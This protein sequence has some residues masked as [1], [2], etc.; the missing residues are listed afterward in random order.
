M[1]NFELNSK[2]IYTKIKFFFWKFFMFLRSLILILTLLCFLH[3]QTPPPPPEVLEKELQSAKDEFERAQKLFNPWFSGP[4]LTGSGNTFP[5]GK[6]GVQPY[7]NIIDNYALFSKSGSSRNI[8]DI[9]IINP[10]LSMLTG[11]TSYLEISTDFGWSFQQQDGKQGNGFN[12][13]GLR[14]G[15]GLS[16]ETETLP[17]VKINI[18]E[19]FPTGRYQNLNPNKN[20]MDGTG[21]G[22]YRTLVGIAA[23][24]VI[25]Y[26]TEHPISLRGSFTFGIPTSVKVTGFNNYGGGYGTNGTVKPGKSIAAAFAFEYSINQ[27][28]VFSNDFVYNYRN[29][30]TFSGNPG[31]NKD[32]SSAA[33]G[34][35]FSDQ[36]SLAPAI[37]Y[38]PKPDLNFIAGGWFAV[39]GRN[40]LRFA[41]F[42]ASVY[43]SF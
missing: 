8:D 32:G 12:D 6:V 20:G 3:A 25:L 27:N 10:Y 16:K 33:V 21:A 2:E 28:W 24:K 29:K 30:H 17:A 14:L 37:E 15:I 43:F 31:T 23:S 22:T 13:T 36:L 19:V 1:K 42:I 7:L 4:L 40:S 34:L 26:E 38:N 9:V 39:W 5:P 11:I 18:K 35:P 41:G